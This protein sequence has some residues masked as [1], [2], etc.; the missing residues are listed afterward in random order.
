MS[1]TRHPL[2][3][4]LSTDRIRPT[5]ACCDDCVTGAA[6]WAR[7]ELQELLAETEPWACDPHD[8]CRGEGC[9]Q[10]RSASSALAESLAAFVADGG[11]Q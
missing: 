11:R 6:S 9:P 5:S 8:D 1:R 4:Y 10:Y 7:Q 2:K 3:A